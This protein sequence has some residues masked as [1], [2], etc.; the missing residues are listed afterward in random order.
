MRKSDDTK[1]QREEKQP[2]KRN[3]FA[4]AAREHVRRHIEAFREL[5][6]R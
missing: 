4:D 2:P 5:A 6:N 3:G 1:K